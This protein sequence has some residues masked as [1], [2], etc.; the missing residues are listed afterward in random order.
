MTALLAL[1]KQSIESLADISDLFEKYYSTFVKDQEKF[2]EKFNLKCLGLI[3][4]FNA[5]SIE[6]KEELIKILNVFEIDYYSFIEA[7]NELE[8]LEIVEVQ[9]GYVKIAEQ[10]L[11]T[12]Y[13]YKC[14][15]RDEL[16]SFELLLFNFFENNRKKFIDTVIPSNNTF[17][18][19]RVMEK[20][21]PTLKTYWDSI[22]IE[23]ERENTYNF[24]LTFW[25]Y[26]QEEAIEYIYLKVEKL[27]KKENPEL[28]E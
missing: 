22:K 15:I 10:N 2:S 7:I 20:L 27:Q 14:F 24:I 18:S 1:K 3:A 8:K 9:Y 13:F 23:T 12:Y 6:D 19:S 25:L 11:A 5:L 16:L 21:S 26:L 4:F 17:G 28:L